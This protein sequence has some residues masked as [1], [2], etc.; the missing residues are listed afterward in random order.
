M[1]TPQT[2]VFAGPIEAL[3]VPLADGWQG[4][5][6]GHRPFYA[7]LMAGQIVLRVGAQERRIA[8]L[9]G[10]LAV[11][12]SS[13][14]VLTGAAALDLDLTRLE[15]GVEAQIEQNAVAEKEA[16]KHFNRVYRQ[17]ARTFNQRPGRQP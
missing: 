8:T 15:Q 11:D 14:T 6:P 4:I 7:R 13:A 12:G 5:W 1:L 9:G 3:T 16:E 10:T 17:L 2:T